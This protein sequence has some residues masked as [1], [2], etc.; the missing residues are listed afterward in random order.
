MRLTYV[1]VQ[2][3]VDYWRV[4]GPCDGAHVETFSTSTFST[5]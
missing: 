5:D 4:G 2:R 3:F 1:G